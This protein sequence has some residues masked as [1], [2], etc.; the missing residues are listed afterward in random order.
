MSFTP[1]F[2][3]IGAMKSGTTW[4]DDMLRSASDARLPNH[5][6]ETFFFDDRWERGVD[7]YAHH[8]EH[9]AVGPAGEV[10]S[11][12]YARAECAER[13]AQTAPR[14]RLA[15][16][17]REPASRS[18]SHFQHLVRKGMLRPDV[19]FADAVELRPEIIEWSRYVPLLAPW[20]DR[21]ADLL[22]VLAYEDLQRDPHRFAG[23]LGTALGVTIDP[24]KVDCT[25][26]YEAR[27][28]RSHLLSKVAARASASLHGAGLHRVVSAAKR[29][30]LD[31][32]VEGHRTD[33]DPETR[34]NA[35]AHAS[36]LLHEDT[37]AAIAAFP[38]LA[39][40]WDSDPG[41]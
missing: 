30:G 5:V 1:D 22:T 16:I 17:L 11:S 29:S 34:R 33:V 24:A 3:V 26:Q 21:Y 8:W 25:A 19:S 38:T 40:A 15:V 6:K 27:S 18:W 13:V 41:R 12:Y 35:L 10:A 23:T 36:V 32:L 28:P 7:W 2:L 14:A 31:R 39:R 4:I 20:R 9:R 37:N